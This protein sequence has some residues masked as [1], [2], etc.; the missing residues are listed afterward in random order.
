[1]SARVLVVVDSLASGGAERMAV[2][3]ACGLDRR[4]Y[5][6]HVV[7]TRG[8][9]PLQEVL[10]RGSVPVTILRRRRRLSAGAYRRAA[11]L[12]RDSD[13]IHAHKFGSAV[14][15][16][17]L[18]RT[19]DRPLI[20]H[21]H[22]WNGTPSAFRSWC[23]RR[24]IAPVATQ[25][26]CVSSSVAAELA[27]DGVPE[28]KVQV[29]QNGVHI[30]AAMTRQE[31]R[32]R[33]RLP[34]VG[35]VVGIVANLRPEKNHELLLRALALSGPRKRDLTVCIV[36]DGP[37]RTHLHDVAHRLGVAG[38][39][40]W[41][42]QVD[43]AD[44]LV[45]AF[46]AAVICSEWE[47]LPLAAL[48]AM[49]A[50]VPV[51][52][53]AVGGLPE[54][55]GGGAGMLV[56]PGDAEALARTLVALSDAPAQAALLGRQGRERARRYNDLADTVLRLEVIYDRALRDRASAGRHLI[57]RAAGEGSR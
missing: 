50:G 17:L 41:T 22:N 45:A 15:G 38:Q 16:A 53:T 33:L 49:A 6:P 7:A 28:A 20:T 52:A 19:T 24:W 25:M 35:F 4:R 57:R 48:E 31:A 55:L 8:G 27:A 36:G 9:G 46:D 32:R 13:L 14:W 39:L 56:P 30:G 29:L 26:M 54:L 3:L 44:R 11:V 21:E 10:E 40:V 18:A 42:G 12:A 34:T 47:G 2:H 43:G 1:M 5:R 23:N 51:V 37:Q